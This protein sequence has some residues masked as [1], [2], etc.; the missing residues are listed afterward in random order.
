[1]VILTTFNQAIQQI[2]SGN[3]R[4]V[5]LLYGKEYYFMEK[6]KQTL[7]AV[8]G[9]GIDE[10]V[11]TYDLRETAIQAVITDVETLP[12]FGDK[13][14]IF[15]HDPVFLKTKQ[16]KIAV[17]HN[18][19]SLE[20]YV[21]NP[22]PYSVLVI[23]APYEK[24]DGRKKVTKQL[25]KYATV[26][27]CNPIK[28]HELRKW[29]HHLAK[30]EKV[31][32]DEGASVLLM[33][34]FQSNLYLLQKE[35]EKLSINVGEGGVI[36]KEITE[37]MMSTTLNHNAL[38]LVDAVL[39]KNLYEA[40]KIYK[41]LEKMREDPIGLIALLAYQFRIIFQVKLLREK[42]LPNSRIQSEVKVHPY[43]AKLAIERSAHFSTKRLSTII[44]VLTNTDAAI[45][46]G[47]VEK[48]MAFELLLYQLIAS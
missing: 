30:E 37:T 31:S 28:E 36:T 39:Q 46:R 41:D 13:K 5:Y 17:A 9:N 48:N 8:W 32:I 16:D 10:D 12:F 11:M 25:K 34:E 15:A 4:P 19:V 44:H 38:Q 2:K 22:V 40:I 33:T 14:L 7:S 24:L 42:G 29:M 6:F 18:V 3:I 26:I 20:N 35:I 45:K 27:D 21:V 1:M 23:I 47:K 43:V